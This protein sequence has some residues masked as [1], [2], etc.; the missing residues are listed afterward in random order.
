[1]KAYEINTTAYDEENF[2]IL[3]DLNEIQIKKVIEP[4]V[5]LERELGIQYTNDS[6][7]DALLD[8][9]PE[10]QFYA[11]TTPKLISI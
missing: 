5:N 3:T 7:I 10:K 4:I 11:Y 8:A 2:V 6:L 9:Y 1:M